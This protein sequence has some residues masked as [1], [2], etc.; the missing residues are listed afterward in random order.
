MIYLTNCDIVMKS[1]SEFNITTIL[2]E[3]LNTTLPPKIIT[4]PDGTSERVVQTESGREIH[5]S[6][7]VSV[8]QLQSD[9]LL[10]NLCT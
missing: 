6:V 8:R 5:A 10:I 2:G 9:L 4:L 3:R 1:M 7:V